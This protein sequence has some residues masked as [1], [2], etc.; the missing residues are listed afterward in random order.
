MKIIF[1]ISTMMHENLFVRLNSMIWRILCSIT[2]V[3]S[4][5]DN[6]KLLQIVVEP[7]STTKNKNLRPISK[8]KT[9]LA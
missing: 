3:Q 8:I 7:I 4:S 6:M 2:H 9:Y 1:Q 5:N